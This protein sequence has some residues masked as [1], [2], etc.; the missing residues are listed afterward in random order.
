MKAPKIPFLPLLLKGALIILSLQYATNSLKRRALCKI[1][2][3]AALRCRNKQESDTC[4][5]MLTK[6]LSV[7]DVT[8]IHEGNK[9]FHDNLVNFEKLVSSWA[10][11]IETYS[12][13]EFQN[14]L[15]NRASCHLYSQQMIADTVRLI[16]QCQKDHMG[17]YS[18]NSFLIHRFINLST[19]KLINTEE[20]TFFCI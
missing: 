8:F 10:F 11:S 2:C 1:F 7:L 4:W 15:F 17:Q 3:Q 18:D 20:R 12:S 9:T 16:R 5:W 14:V 19:H 13:D 6:S